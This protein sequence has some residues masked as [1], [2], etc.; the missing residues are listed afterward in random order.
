MKIRH[1]PIFDTKVVEDLYT[2]KDGVPVSYVCTTGREKDTYAR[3]IFYRETPHPTFGNRYF[4][5]YHDQERLLYN[6]SHLMI[7]AA[8]WVEDLKFDMI[9]SE[10]WYFYSSHRWDMVNTAVGS[11]DGGRAYTR[12]GG[13]VIPKVE[14]FV[15]RNG[16]FVG[17]TDE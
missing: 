15:V 3:D 2:K 13:S 4:G 16:K 14:T 9:K 7:S 6:T 1:Y 11:I 8:D 5:L 12:L 10:G 17:K